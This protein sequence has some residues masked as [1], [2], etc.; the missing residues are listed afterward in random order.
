MSAANSI[1]VSEELYREVSKRAEE[2][3]LSLQDWANS[4]LATRVQL[5]RQTDTFFDSRAAGASARP[6]GELLDKAP[7]RPADQGD[8]LDE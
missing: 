1:P 6:L 7:D 8:G 4:V 5:E 3:G 2:V